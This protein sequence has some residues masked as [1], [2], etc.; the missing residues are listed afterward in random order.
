MHMYHMSQVQVS[1]T[2]CFMC[3][4]R[5]PDVSWCL[6]LPDR[7][8]RE[9]RW[10]SGAVTSGIWRSKYWRVYRRKHC[11]EAKKGSAVVVF[12]AVTAAQAAAMQQPLQ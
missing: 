3:Q 12:V 10:I 2:P 11:E 5:Q 4:G 8:A 7:P 9:V 1:G 6:A